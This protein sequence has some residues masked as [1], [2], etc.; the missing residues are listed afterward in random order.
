MAIAN[1]TG[2]T[3]L[4]NYIDSEW[5]ARQLRLA[6][7][8]PFVGESV[9]G[10]VDLSPMSTRTYAHPLLSRMTAA[11]A[12]AEGDEFSST[13]MATVEQTI[14]VGMVSKSTFLTPQARG[15]TVLDSAAAAVRNVVDAVRQKIENDIIGLSSSMSNTIGTNAQTFDLDYWNTCLT[16]F[17]AQAKSPNMAAAVLH[18]D[19]VRDLHGDLVTANAAL[20]GS[21]F[22]PPAA[23]A[24]G[25]VRQG[26]RAVL[27][28]LPIY[29]T[30][31][32]PVAD[33]TGWGNFIVE[34]GA[35]PGL[36]LVVKQALSLKIDSPAN[37]LGE[38]VNCHSD[39]GT[40]IVDSNRCLQCVSRT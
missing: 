7:E 33:T 9:V 13:T 37:A 15:A 24:T 8:T 20:F 34:T 26:A 22:G 3:A 1:F 25:G 5:I 30:D 27:D 39:Y 18:P 2:T 10:Y 38:W 23:D 31:A 14:A 32:V 29:E 36:M 11:A 17:R 21:S 35:N 6:V 4:T 12:Y 40:G 19:A 28:G 16:T